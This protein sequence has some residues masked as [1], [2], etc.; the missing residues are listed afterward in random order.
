MFCFFLLFGII[1]FYRV[2]S[3]ILCYCLGVIIVG[4]ILYSFRFWFYL[5]LWKYVEVRLKVD[6]NV[7]KF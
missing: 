2:V 7:E 4:M 5:F 6:D 3:K 1:D